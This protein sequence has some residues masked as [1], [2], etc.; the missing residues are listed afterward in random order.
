MEGAD[1]RHGRLPTPAT[2]LIGRE[3]DIR[4][5]ERL[6][7][8][9]RLVTLTGA[10]GSGKTRVAIEVASRLR[11]RYQDG[12]RFVAVQDAR[13]RHGVI[14]AVA[15]ALA[16]TE[17]VDSGLLEGIETLLE[18][19]EIL[20]VLDNFEQVLEAASLVSGLLE[21]A[22]RLSV[23]V[24]S[25]APL[26][27]AAEQEREVLPLDPASASR[28]FV[29]RLVAVR[30]TFDATGHE[31]SIGGIVRRVD[32]LPLAVELAAAQVRHLTPEM[33][34][35]RLERSLPVL[36]G[37]H[38]DAPARQRTQ[39][40]TLDWSH[41][42]LSEPAGR[43]FAAL[44]VFAGGWTLEA[45]E[46]VCSDAAGGTGAVFTSLTELVESSLVRVADSDGQDVR[47]SMHQLTREYAADRLSGMPEH[48]S[49]ELRQAEWVLDLV[50]TAEPRLVLRDLRA[51]QERLRVEEDN[52][53][54]ALRWATDHVDTELG[55]RIAGLLWRF[56]FH[57]AESREGIAWL[58]AL[59]A[60]PGADAPGEP[61]A[62]ALSSLAALKWHQ[63]H[64]AESLEAYLEVLDILRM[65]GIEDVRF[66]DALDDTTWAASMNGD[67]ELA[68][69]LTAEKWRYPLRRRSWRIDGWIDR[70][71][72]LALMRFELG[73][74]EGDAIEIIRALEAILDDVDRSE[75]ALLAAHLR[76]TI[77]AYQATS[78]R[79]DLGFRH[80]RE[81]LRR[82]RDL[83]HRGQ[84]PIMLMTMAFHE[85]RLGRP[86]RALRLAA[87][88]GQGAAEVGG[89][90]NS[91]RD[92][93]GQG[94]PDLEAASR[95]PADEVARAVREGRAMSTDEAIA[96]ALHELPEGRTS[97]AVSK[98]RHDLTPREQ[99]VLALLAGGRTD[100]EI[101][102][103]LVISKK[104][105]SVH[106]AS[107]KGKL[108]AGSRA[109]IVSIA[110]RSG[111]AGEA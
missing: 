87:A 63:G 40:A 97:R 7:E 15:D 51:W 39:R 20:L 3:A 102:E 11:H 70:E 106:V 38:R 8:D 85:L 95:L 73:G 48:E 42:L 27:I 23:I 16:V 86:E 34:L 90:V 96:Y 2:R 92:F 9:H 83:G 82:Y 77:G 29:E 100:G 54:R 41:D 46:R 5:V 50:A 66:S 59:L 88:A 10:G 57:W 98:G 74:P 107:I 31:D 19:R 101:A 26:R 67:I 93:S 25:R 56:W 24:T 75:Q 79:D 65:L 80:E 94:R 78:R 91:Q 109:E 30:P 17:R 58:E 18:D 14:A 47:Y 64:F 99:E 69:R 22:P 43:L 28:I 49:I 32:C 36:E 110:L 84:L 53:R 4:A 6:L 105:A 111:L 55:L 103:A 45:A 62:L 89:I 108:G 52:I 1:A 44:S 12:A 33:I 61:R 13:D 72:D 21:A 35:E 71:L 68:V 37:G 60:L 76:A 81:A 104:T